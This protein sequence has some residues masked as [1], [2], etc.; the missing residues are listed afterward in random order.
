MS[1]SEKLLLISCRENSGPT[2]SNR[3]NYQK[4]WT[5]VKLIELH[6]TKSDY[7]I[8][9]DYHEDVVILDSETNPTTGTF[10]QV[11]TRD[12]HEPWTSARLTSRKTGKDGEKLNSIMGKL[13]IS[14]DKF[15]GYKPDMAVVS[16][17]CFSFK[18]SG[19]DKKATLD[20]VKL[21]ELDA[22]EISKIDKAIKDECDIDNCHLKYECCFEVA[23]LHL[24][25]HSSH[26]Q[27]K[28]LKFLQ[29]IGCDTTTDATALYR[30]LFDTV[31]NKTDIEG[32][33]QSHQ[34]LLAKK[35]IGK[36][37]VDDV[38][39][40]IAKSKDI[41]EMWSML[42]GALTNEGASAVKMV[43]IRHEWEQFDI[44]RLDPLNEVVQGL[45]K[46]VGNTVAAIIEENDDITITALVA[47]VTEQ[48]DQK[49]LNEFSDNY[50]L[51]VVFREMYENR[52]V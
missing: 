49:Y 22:D 19:Q 14:V 27:G 4:D 35:G 36:S 34:E 15:S 24:K 30:V 23:N 32:K 45:R 42:S 43:K 6:T 12:S 31:K 25:D 5:I 46:K 18:L 47:A 16:N 40:T 50:I 29:D 1:L 21:A 26:T 9:C 17:N 44:D 41:K 33:L 11:K 39:N 52:P 8:F 7:L 10:V 13:A 37:Y 2:A 48:L 28:L 3:F 38:V 51:A 20:L